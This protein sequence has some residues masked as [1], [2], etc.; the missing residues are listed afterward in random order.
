MKFQNI[1]N[2]NFK[3]DQNTYHEYLDLPSGKYEGDYHL[4]NI[5]GSP[6]T[7]RL[8]NT[9]SLKLFNKNI[10]GENAKFEKK[11]TYTKNFGNNLIFQ[12]IKEFFGQSISQIWYIVCV[13]YFLY[14]NLRKW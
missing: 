5:A 12:V 11:F 4:E 8:N 7:N 9:N 6:Y 3:F 13:N 10:Y 1:D 14:I 2:N